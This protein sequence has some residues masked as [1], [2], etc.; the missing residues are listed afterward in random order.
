MVDRGMSGG[1]QK[2]ASP[3]GFPA[4]PEHGCWPAKPG[5]VA[6]CGPAFYGTGWSA[7]RAAALADTAIWGA[8]SRRG[9]SAVLADGVGK[10]LGNYRLEK[11]L[12]QGATAA[13]Y[14]GRDARTGR[15]VA[16][17]AVALPQHFAADQIEAARKRFF[18][19]AETA[20]RLDHEHIV[21]IYDA[22]E[23]NGLAYIA[24]E[25]LRGEDL[26]ASATPG[27]LLPLGQVLSI[28][29]RVAQ[30]LAYAHC[31]GVVHRDIKPANIV[32]EGDRDVVKVADF[33]I[34]CLTDA[35]KTG[36]DTL[37]GTPS[38]MSPEQLS[39]GETGGRSDLFSLGVTLYQ[40]CC[41]HLPFQG[42]SLPHLMFRIA[43]EP[44]ADILAYAPSLPSGVVEAIGRALAKQPQDRYQSGEEMAQALRACMAE[45]GRPAGAAAPV[46]G[47]T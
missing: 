26:S 44:H 12:G 20:G 15:T 25:F 13:I 27:G 38:Y 29:A 3:A 1:R 2:V 34:A 36:S 22:G 24:M 18:L 10:T 43:N 17:K 6:G 42:N 33:G 47:R 31:R 30:A 37:A 11:K 19:E 5:W 28:V 46:S 32:Y 39:G 4:Q 8:G 14:R 23:E 41:G 35:A 40:L 9:E 16:I 45:A 7:A 21:S